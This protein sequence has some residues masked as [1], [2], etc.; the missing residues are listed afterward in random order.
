MKTPNLFFRSS[1]AMLSLAVLLLSACIKD[2][3]G[4]GGKPIKVKT[5]VGTDFPANDGLFVSPNG[6]IFASDF[7]VFDPVSGK[8]SGTT[9][10]Q[11]SRKG[12][13][14]EKATGFEAPMAGVTDRYGNFYFTNENNNDLV[15]GILVKIA[16]DGTSSQLAE[17]PGW[18]SGLTIDEDDNIYA[19]NFALPV[20]NK[21]TPDGT[22]STFATDDRLAGCVGIDFDKHGNIV[23]A[24]FSTADVLSIDPEAQVSLITTI[25]N[26]TAGFAIGY[27]T[28]FEDAIYATG[29]NE[30][31]I[32]KITLD[33]KTSIFAGTGE[34]GSADGKLSKATFSNPNGI[35]AD[36][37]KR[38]LYI[39]QFGTP[40]L[41]KIKF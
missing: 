38:I 11:V 40:G 14:T 19:A 37:H 9:V 12:D 28:I 21:I 29:I 25:P 31:V 6:T 3:E 20:I 24:N 4:H 27:M 36:H 23:T 10:Y 32:F 5:L 7:G 8:G 1:V 39:S 15:S 33:G 22:V 2:F 18:P 16:P 26:V 30:N 35:A 34:N 17:I 41:R 13:I